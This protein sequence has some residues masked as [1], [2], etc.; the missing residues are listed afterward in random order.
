MA[1]EVALEQPSGAATNYVRRVAS[2]NSCRGNFLAREGIYR[3]RLPTT[4]RMRAPFRSR[5]PALGDSR[6][7]RFLFAFVD[8][9]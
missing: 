8:L 5:L 3:R 6:S 9:L 2:A 1:G 4:S 7:T